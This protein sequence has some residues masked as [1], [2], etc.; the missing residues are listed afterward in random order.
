MQ[1]LLEIGL[2]LSVMICQ[3]FPKEIWTNT[4][5]ICAFT[6]RKVQRQHYKGTRS[7]AVVAAVDSTYK[8]SD[9]WQLLVNKG[10]IL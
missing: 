9:Q 2:V 8:H 7:V 5:L 4:H 3:L 1:D 10:V 6:L